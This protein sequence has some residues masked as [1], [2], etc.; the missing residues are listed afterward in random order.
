MRLAHCCSVCA[1]SGQPLSIALHLWSLPHVRVCVCV[2]F[3]CV[4][5]CVCVCVQIE[6]LAQ[7]ANQGL[8]DIE[9]EEE[10]EDLGDDEGDDPHNDRED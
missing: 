1:A 6:Q 9:G 3:V 10:D 4:C 7:L 5:V 8:E 2:Y